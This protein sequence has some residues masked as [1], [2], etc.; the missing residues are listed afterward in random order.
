MLQTMLNPITGDWEEMTPRQWWLIKLGLGKNAVVDDWTLAI[1]KGPE[2][3]VQFAFGKNQWDHPGANKWLVEKYKEWF[4]RPP[5]AKTFCEW[6]YF[7]SDV[8]N[9]EEHLPLMEKLHYIKV[10]LLT[11]SIDKMKLKQKLADK[12]DAYNARKFRKLRND[13]HRN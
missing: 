1:L 7:I 8:Y 10:G 13:S 4:P 2:Y 6:C 11:N 12:M 3:A 9:L 5:N